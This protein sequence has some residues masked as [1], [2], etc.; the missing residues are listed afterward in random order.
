LDKPS[1]TSPDVTGT[2]TVT[3]KAALGATIY[4]STTGPATIKS[5]EYKG[6]FQVTTTTTVSA[7]A[8]QSGYNNSLA[9]SVEIKYSEPIVTLASVKVGGISVAITDKMSITLPQFTVRADVVV[10]STDGNAM[11]STYDGQTPKAGGNSSPTTEYNGTRTD[12]I[13]VTN[14]PTAKKIYSPA[15][16]GLNTVT[17]QD[18]YRGEFKAVRLGTQ[19]WMQ[20]NLAFIPAKMSPGHCYENIQANCDKYGALYNK[21]EVDYFGGSICP[22][23]FRI[24]TSAD[25][26]AWKGDYY[27][28]AIKHMADWGFAEDPTDNWYGYSVLP[29]GHCTD[30]DDEYNTIPYQCTGLGSAALFWTSD[31]IDAN[32]LLSTSQSFGAYTETLG[33]EPSWHYGSIRCI[34]K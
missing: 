33:S 27:G 30:R 26:A 31:P 6:P 12:V 8:I 29:G 25:F 20:K 10:T 2:R 19:W 9:A 28:D 32:T 11:V 16:T 23:G 1:I 4:Y 5:M 24:P 3:I 22:E 17:V 18:Q 21:T 7:I 34:K 13:T 14:G 15:I